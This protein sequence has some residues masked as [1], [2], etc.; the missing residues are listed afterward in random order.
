AAVAERAADKDVVAAQTEAGLRQGGAGARHGAARPGRLTR[1][2]E[3]V[4]ARQRAARFREGARGDNGPGAEVDLPAGERQGRPE[5]GH[6]AGE[7]DGAA[8]D[9]DVAGEVDAPGVG[10][11][12]GREINLAGSRKG[13]SGGQGEGAAAELERATRFDD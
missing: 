7:V 13:R 4:A 3:R 11:R 2:L 10:D 1:H 5:A 8:V 6:G 9:R 12:T